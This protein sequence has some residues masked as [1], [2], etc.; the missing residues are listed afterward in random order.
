MSKI[1][2]VGGHRSPLQWIAGLKDYFFFFFT[3]DFLPPEALDADDFLEPPPAFFAE[4]AFPFPP[5]LAFSAG[6]LLPPDGAA[7]PEEG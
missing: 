1:K 7:P 2:S 5:F 6:G 4:E 3:P